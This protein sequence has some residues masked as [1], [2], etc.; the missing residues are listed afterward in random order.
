MKRTLYLLVL[1]GIILLISCDSPGLN[2]GDDDITPQP[3]TPGLNYTLIDGPA[4]S[5]SLGSAEA[6]HIVI[7]STYNGLPVASIREN[8]FKDS[9]ILSVSIPNSITSIGNNAFNSCIG[10]T[11]VKIPDSVT[12]IDGGA[13][14]GCTGIKNVILG[15]SITSLNGTF[16]G[17]TRLS[18][19]TIPNN[20]ISLNGTFYGCT[21]LTS[22]T[23]PN[24]VT[25]IGD[26]T[27]NGCTNLSSITIPNS[28]TSIGHYTFIGCTSLTSITIP[29]S[30]TSIGF[31]FGGWT[32]SQTIKIPLATLAEADY[33]WSLSWRYSCN[34]TIKN[35]AGVQIYP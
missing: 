34:A 5:V 8:G 13:F 17:C 1:V 15:N 30:V 9:A 14:S 22:I 33:K 12:S 31:S 23:I 19:I 25:S 35:N 21:G 2:E 24:S 16:S 3:P 29:N 18:S 10:L 32:S 6:A 7:P 4:Y 27:F 20:V 28:L 26:Y 11:N